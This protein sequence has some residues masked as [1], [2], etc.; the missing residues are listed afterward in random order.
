MWVTMDFIRMSK[1]QDLTGVDTLA[2][3]G[4]KEGYGASE[5][6]C[7][8]LRTQWDGGRGLQKRWLSP[9]SLSRA[10]LGLPPGL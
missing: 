1:L 10:D 8:F 7:A 9:Y 4:R 2:L 3:Q 6:R 5:H